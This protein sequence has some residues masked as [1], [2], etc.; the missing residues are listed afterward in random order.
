M[1]ELY[2][3]QFWP[4]ITQ[5]HDFSDKES[6]VTDYKL[7][8]IIEIQPKQVKL[9]LI[10]LLLI[11]KFWKLRISETTNCELRGLV[12]ISWIAN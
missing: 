6:D 7:K 10:A 3:N 11:S 9:Y 12:Y 1:W 8:I 2:F 5:N 4:K